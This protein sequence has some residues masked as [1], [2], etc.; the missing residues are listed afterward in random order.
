[1]VAADLWRAVLAGML[2]LADHRVAAAYA[3]VFGL[4]AGAVF[5]NPASA[6][7]LPGIVGKANWWQ[8]TAARG[9]RRSCPRLC[10]RDHPGAACA[11][12]ASSPGGHQRSAASTNPRIAGD[13]PRDPLRQF[14]DL[15]PQLRVLGF[16]LRVLRPQRHNH[17]SITVAVFRRV[18]T[19]PL[20]VM[21]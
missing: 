20:S 6:S 8:R 18:A 17:I 3:L 4:S 10:S 21:W 15:R 14:R 13:P 11:P 1:M 19:L 9:R 7:V 12:G 16:Q 2:P 5:F